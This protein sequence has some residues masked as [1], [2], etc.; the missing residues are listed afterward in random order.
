MKKKLLAV[1]VIAGGMLALTGCG[2]TKVDLNKYVSIEAK[3][4]DTIGE[5][6][7][8]FDY[9]AFNDDY[10]KKIKN[11]SKDNSAGL[12][13]GRTSA[14]LL[15]DYCVAKNLTPS[16]G[17]SN[18]DTVTLVWD[19]KDDLAEEY[20]DCKLNYSDIDYTVSGLK[21][22]ETFDPFDYVDVTFSGTAPDGVVAIAPDYEEK[23]AMQYVKFSAD[24]SSNLENGDTVMVTAS[25]Q[26]SSEDFIKKYGAVLGKTKNSYTVDGLAE[27]IHD[28]SEVPSDIYE[29]M[30]K[31]LR[32]DLMSDFAGWKNEDLKNM[33]LL[34]NYVLSLK[35][36]K[37]SS[38]NNR[39][40]FVY[41]VTAENDQS[42]GEF[43][44]YWY[45]YFCDVVL[46]PDETCETD[47]SYYKTPGS[48]DI[49]K[50][51]GQSSYKYYGF[52]DIKSLYE[53]CVVSNIDDYEYTSTVQ[54]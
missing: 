4:Y 9:E 26:G 41:N 10:G 23:N 33:E 13:S 44:Y 40:I 50:F 51:E 2:S 27:Y 11:K 24:K 53:N 31:Q 48:A 7:Y 32:D 30:D 16:K 5:A 15:I 22:V 52:K 39:V 21:E 17:L 8:S 18:G 3:G 19:C 43:N 47:L 25:I 6:T 38:E 20:F 1:F 36:G 35:D 49:I 54:E 12:L 28:I 42:N 14:E 29:K 46:L 34:G 37:K 45:G